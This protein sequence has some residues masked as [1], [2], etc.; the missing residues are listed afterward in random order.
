MLVLL[1]TR[2]E[3]LVGIHTGVDNC[4]LELATAAINRPGP[5]PASSG[6]GCLGIVLLGLAVIARLL[7]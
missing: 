7:Y 5:I 1:I 4:Q 2:A 6:P 3:E